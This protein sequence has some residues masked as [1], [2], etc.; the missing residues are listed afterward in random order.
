[1]YNYTYLEMKKAVVFALANYDDDKIEKLKQDKSGY[2]WD[3][4]KD[5]EEE[6][7]IKI[8]V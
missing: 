2:F 8:K 3:V 7:E 4:I 1:M 6:M 5:L